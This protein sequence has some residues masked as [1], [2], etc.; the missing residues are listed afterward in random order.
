MSL[1]TTIINELTIFIILLIEIDQLRLQLIVIMVE[2]NDYV[3]T[4]YFRKT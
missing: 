3:L 1:I 2:I 4:Y